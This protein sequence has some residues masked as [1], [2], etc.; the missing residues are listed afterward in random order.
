MQQM[1]EE[2]N[3]TPISFE[4]ENEL[5]HRFL[6]TLESELAQ[7]Q[8]SPASLQDPSSE[9]LSDLPQIFSTFF[10]NL[11]VRENYINILIS[12]ISNFSSFAI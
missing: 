2:N 12:I 5:I 7:N 4:E 3:G 9:F 10:Q 6:L 1:L 11:Y 8:I